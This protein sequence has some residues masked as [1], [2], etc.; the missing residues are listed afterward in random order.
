[1]ISGFIYVKNGIRYISTETNF[2]KAEIGKGKGEVYKNFIDN[3]H[4]TL[5]V[6]LEKHI[7]RLKMKGVPAEEIDI[8][9]AG[10]MGSHGEIRALDRLLTTIDPEGKLGEAV[11]HD[12]IGYNRYLRIADKLQPP[13]VHCYYLTS[14]IR[15]MGF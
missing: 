3:I 4:P 15:F 12:I 8:L 7:A 9:R 1:M 11:F 14:G 6:R 5:K 2:L 13:C 10:A